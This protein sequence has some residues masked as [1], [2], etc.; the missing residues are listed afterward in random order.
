MDPMLN[1]IIFRSV[2]MD[3]YK[4]YPKQFRNERIPIEKNTCFFIMPFAEKFDIVYGTIKNGL[5][6]DYI[7][8]RVDE[9]SGSIPIIN[10][11]LVEILK[12]QFIIVDLSDSNPNVFY[13]LGIAHT[14]K[15][16]QNIFLLKNK[17][18]K[19][20]FDITHLT[21]I[22]Y[23]TNNLKYVV[24]QLKKAISD[25]KSFSD[26]NEALN[27]HG[28]IDFNH[29]N[30]NFSLNIIYDIL[31]EHLPLAVDIL[32]FIPDLNSKGIK[33]FLDYLYIKI[34]SIFTTLNQC[35]IKIILELFF[36][37]LL[38]ANT[39]CNVDTFLNEIFSDFF[40]HSKLSDNEIVTFQTQCALKFASKNAQLSIVMP[41]IINYF[42]RSK[43]ATIDLNRYS[44]ESF[45][46]T[47]NLGEINKMIC[48]A[49]CD[50]DAHI[51]EHFANIIGEKNLYGA[52]DILSSQLQCEKNFYVAASIIVALG[53]LR[54]TEKVAK[55]LLWI[56]N[57]TAEII[58]TKSYFVLKHTYVALTKLDEQS[59]NNFKEKFYKQITS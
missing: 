16:A 48:D 59:A 30:Q 38:A 33:K 7:C 4:I 9:I 42:K 21:Y 27:V 34:K 43:F 8:K 52:K 46:L 6:D 5:Q 39:W 58:S 32:N 22:E 14:F 23:D 12:A 45:L 31:G 11:I 54:A 40:I 53:E 15:D 51:R 44:L 35:D 47:S 25:N 24:A 50:K 56:D 1:I 19:V 20:P 29:E 57:N 3:K 17:N 36:E 18:S 13:E 28:I 10:K 2:K 37:I 41:W 26:L 49:I 55:I